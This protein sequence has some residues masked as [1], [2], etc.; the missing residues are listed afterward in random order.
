MRHIIL[1]RQEQ[2]SDLG[3]VFDQKMTFSSHIES[4]VSSASRMLGFIIRNG[5]QFSVSVLKLLYTFYVRS[6][7]EY[8]VLI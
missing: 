3:I 6:K 7:L 5:R 4:T 8:G 1:S 2:I